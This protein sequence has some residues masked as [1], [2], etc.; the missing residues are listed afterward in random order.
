LDVII[1]VEES[2]ILATGK[3][4]REALSTYQNPVIYEKEK[5]A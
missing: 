2:E 3:F 1:P 4:K 5:L